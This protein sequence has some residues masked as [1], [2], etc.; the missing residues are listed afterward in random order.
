VSEPNYFSLNSD[1]CPLHLALLDEVVSNHPLLH[2]RVLS[3]FTSLF[4]G[5]YGRKKY[6]STRQQCCGSEPESERI[7]I[8]WLGPNPKKKFGFGFGSR[9]C[10]KIKIKIW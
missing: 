9:H 3:L 10:Y 6:L 1:Y 8:C 5:S 4:E 7:R 2:A